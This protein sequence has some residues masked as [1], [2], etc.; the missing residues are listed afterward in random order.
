[1]NTVIPTVTI[2][3]DNGPVRINHSD[4]DPAIHTLE[5]S[6]ITG[7]PNLGTNPDEPPLPFAASQPEP[8]VIGAP[9][10]VAAATGEPVVP[11]ADGSVT[12]EPPVAPVSYLVTKTG[13]KYFV[14]NAAGEKITGV[15][16][17]DE[18]GY[19]AEGDAWAAVAAKAS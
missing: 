2:V 7:I 10:L 11:E 6:P 18:K 13:S 1:M 12:V 4:Y 15:E 16:G 17:I 3:T 19:K 14:V 9:T 5:V 8:V